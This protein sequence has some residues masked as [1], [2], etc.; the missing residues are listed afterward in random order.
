MNNRTLD[1]RREF[2]YAVADYIL[3]KALREV[4]VEDEVIEVKT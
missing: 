2:G 4:F 3:I 1:N